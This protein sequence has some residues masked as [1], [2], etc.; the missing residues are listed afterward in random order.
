MFKKYLLLLA[1]ILM[2]CES[3]EPRSAKIDWEMH[4]RIAK[5]KIVV[6]LLE[7]TQ[8]ICE[9]KKVYGKW[10]SNWE[11]YAENGVFDYIDLIGMNENEIDL[12]IRISN[13]NEQISYKQ[14]YSFN[15]FTAEVYGFNLRVKQPFTCDSGLTNPEITNEIAKYLS[16]Y[17]VVR[18]SILNYVPPE[19]TV[20]ERAV[21]TVANLS[22][23]YLFKIQPRSCL[24]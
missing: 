10:P 13:F 15:R 6:P 11:V 5:E 9:N 20:V 8:M 17:V 24:N 18:D 19:P 1:I 14:I 2:G 3:T 23:C 22:V 16:K 21:T 12:N 4:E 7:L